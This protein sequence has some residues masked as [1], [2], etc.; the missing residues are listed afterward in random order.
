MERVMTWA[1]LLNL[2]KRIYI[3]VTFLLKSTSFAGKNTYT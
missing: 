1:K 2:K 3:F